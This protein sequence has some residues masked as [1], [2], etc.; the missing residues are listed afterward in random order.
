MVATV[1]DFQKAVKDNIEATLAS[2]G[3][4]SK[5]LQAIAAET[6]DYSKKS[7]E[8]ASKTFEKLLGAKS[9]DAVVEAQTEYVKKSYEDAIAQTSKIATLSA[10][11]AKDLY[12]PVENFTA[13][14]GK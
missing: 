5:G 1:E 7:V 14:F 8:D 12:K 13:K 4:L 6:T 10:D 3:M 11:L 9:L 2:V